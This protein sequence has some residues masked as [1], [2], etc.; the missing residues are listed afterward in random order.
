MVIA[1]LVILGVDLIVLV[2]FLAFVL[3]WQRWVT[4]QPG[5]FHGAIRVTNGAVDGFRPKW[6]RGY[7]GWVR[8]V[9]VWAKAPFLFRNELI[10]IDSVGEHRPAA[11][12]DVKRLGSDPIIVV[13]KAGTATVE[14]AA[15]SD[16][17]DRVTGPFRPAEARHV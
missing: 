7:G 16:D 1:L 12:G 15:H 6:T 13:L 2:V 14:I 8:D 10:A 9:L 5:V 4:R 17:L 11:P 3:G